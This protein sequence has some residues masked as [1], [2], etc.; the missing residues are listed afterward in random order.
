MRWLR[1]AINKL[2]SCLWSSYVV[3]WELLGSG[4]LRVVLW[5]LGCLKS[6][7]AVTRVLL[8]V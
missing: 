1:V 5:L 7:Y 6:F 2:L 4:I 3:T 8:G